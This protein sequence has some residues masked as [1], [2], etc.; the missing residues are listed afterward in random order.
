MVVMRN[1]IKREDGSM[2]GSDNA[3]EGLPWVDFW[4]R[5]ITVYFGHD[6]KRGIQRTDW[7]YGLDSGC[8]YGEYASYIVL[9]HANRQL[10]QLNT[11]SFKYQLRQ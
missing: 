4:D 11:F 2:E 3:K 9:M 7:A 5:K 1:I 8:C 6:A 10:P